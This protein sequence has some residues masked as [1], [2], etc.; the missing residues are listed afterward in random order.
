MNYTHPHLSI[1]STANF[2]QSTVHTSTA[3]NQKVHCKTNILRDHRAN[4]RNIR[5]S[6]LILVDSGGKAVYPRS[7]CRQTCSGRDERV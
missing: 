4:S 1:D 3:L 6:Y 5:V 2:L 7:T